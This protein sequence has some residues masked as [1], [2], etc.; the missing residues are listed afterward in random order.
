MTILLKGPYS[1]K[2]YI[3]SQ[4]NLE[5]QQETLRQRIELI[6]NNAIMIT[7]IVGILY[8]LGAVI[9]LWTHRYEPIDTA[10]PYLIGSA[11]S[12]LIIALITYHFSV[13]P[14]NKQKEQLYE[15]SKQLE[16]KTI[17]IIWLKSHYQ[18]T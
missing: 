4:D 17:A 11:I 14:Y 7:L 13:K 9:Y 6:K 16:K 8:C 5:E 15:E 10:R 12:I 2:D 18:S 1:R 3:N